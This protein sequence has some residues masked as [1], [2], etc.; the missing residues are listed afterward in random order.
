[1]HEPLP[2]R[3]DDQLGAAQTGLPIAVTVPW[4]VPAATIGACLALAVRPA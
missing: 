2:V 1:M 4:P 3:H